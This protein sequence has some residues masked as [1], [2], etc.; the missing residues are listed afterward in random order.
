MWQKHCDPDVQKILDWQKAQQRSHFDIAGQV[1]KDIK[2]EIINPGE[3][4]LTLTHHVVTYTAIVSA[5]ALG[6]LALVAPVATWTARW[7]WRKGRA[8]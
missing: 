1:L 6:P 5:P 3:E 7:L 2:D 4:G 8:K